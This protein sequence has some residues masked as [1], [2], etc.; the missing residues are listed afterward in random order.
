MVGGIER[1]TLA[2]LS[3][4]RVEPFHLPCQPLVEIG[5]V[6]LLSEDGVGG[7]DGACVVLHAL[8]AG[9]RHGLGEVGPCLAVEPQLVLYAAYGRLPKAWR[10]C[11]AACHN[12]LGKLDEA[13]GLSGGDVLGVYLLHPL[14]EVGLSLIARGERHV[15]RAIHV[16]RLLHVVHEVLHEVSERG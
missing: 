2:I 4:L 9:E 8:R 5:V 3:R 13:V 15:A 7:I 1:G 16:H 12:A 11:L 10:A 6:T 14:V